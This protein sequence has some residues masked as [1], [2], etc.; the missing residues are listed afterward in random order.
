MRGNGYQP[1]V[2]PVF[3]STGLFS[4]IIALF[5]GHAVKQTGP[6]GGA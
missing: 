5:G 6:E 1:D 2:G 4:G 3:I